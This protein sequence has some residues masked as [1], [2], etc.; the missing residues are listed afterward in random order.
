MCNSI[1][2]LIENAHLRQEMSNRSQEN[3]DKFSKQ[4]IVK[5]WR[6]LIDSL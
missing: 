3:L 6:E 2:E 4:S 5:Q 1:C